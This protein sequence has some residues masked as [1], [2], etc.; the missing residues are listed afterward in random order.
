MP[1]VNFALALHIGAGHH[2][3]L[4]SKE[5]MELMRETL[6]KAREELD[7][8]V[9]EFHEMWKRRG[10]RKELHS[11]LD[12]MFCPILT[13]VIANLENSTLTNAG[14]S[15]NLTRYKSITE[16]D[17]CVMVGGTEGGKRSR[18]GAIGAA[19][20]IRNPIKG[21]EWLMERSSWNT[22]GNIVSRSLTEPVM[23]TGLGLW[24]KIR[25][26]REGA[27]KDT[28][29]NDQTQICSKRLLFPEICE[30]P[31]DLDSFLVHDSAKKRWE[32]F[33][34]RL[35]DTVGAV[36]MVWLE[37]N[38]EDSNQTSH[39]D[40][41]EHALKASYST[42][43]RKRRRLN[44]G[45]YI[46]Q[47]SH[48]G[49]S[50]FCSVTGVSSGGIAMKCEG[51]VGEAALAGIGCYADAHC[52]VSCTGAGEDIMLSFSARNI[53]EQLEKDISGQEAIWNV[54]VRDYVSRRD[55]QKGAF[56]NPKAQPRNIMGA[57]VL[58]RDTDS[59][60]STPRKTR[61]ALHCAFT[62][63]SMGVAHLSS[64][65]DKIHCSIHRQSQENVGKNMFY[66]EINLLQS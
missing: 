57:L 54:I 11:S 21:A 41:D 55:L 10:V 9:A 7:K 20:G 12:Q 50:D 62:A 8:K 58:S 43:A 66:Q 2:S 47:P 17:A 61:V 32:V 25:R 4:K 1:R 39:S 37:E 18:W 30:N 33:N 52:S 6:K 31:T 46:Y 23:L 48:G 36:M 14:L 40:A 3:T 15:S 64:F 44:G 19:R 59:E 45:D 35:Y 42:R 34:E 24:E 49:P 56:D 29:Q 28:P 27:E 13:N 22:C 63:W 53:A 60:S 51:R 38:E 5:Y 26:E 16:C 65:D